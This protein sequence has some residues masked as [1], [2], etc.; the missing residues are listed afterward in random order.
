[1]R[2]VTYR[3]IE[4]QDLKDRVGV[5]E[6]G[7]IRQ[8][9]GVTRLLDL[10]VAPDGLLSAGQTALL[11]VS[12]PLQ[13]AHLRPPIPEPPSFRDFMAFEAHVEGTTLNYGPD[14]KPPKVWYRQPLFYFS[15]P[16]AMYGPYDEVPIA[17]GSQMF[18]FEL[19]V[20]AV[21]GH[22]GSNLT[23]QEAQESIAGYMV[24]ND[25]SARDLQSREMTGNL[26]PSKGK[27]TA[28]TIG[29]ALVTADE[30]EPFASGPSFAL[31]ME[32]EINGKRF[33]GDRLDNIAW[34]FA[35]LISY[36]SRGTKIATGDIFGSGT[37]GMG[38]IAEL[39]GREGHDHPMLQAGDTVTMRVEELGEI[40]NRLVDPAPIHDIGPSRTS[41]EP[42]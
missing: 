35:Q 16:T 34:S 17:P 9:S 11:E 32:V 25:W 42:N 3:L 18:D 38:C 2:F 22:G 7:V 13:E 30:L 20:A 26:G 10:L 40:S 24:L 14:A 39:W 5:L 23:L 19:E 37:C 29:P 1:M 21:I 27:D 28:T 6:D 12:I 4:D 36:A 15:N 33:G 41:S 31:E 8:L